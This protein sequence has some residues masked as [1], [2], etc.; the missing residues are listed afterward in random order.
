VLAYRHGIV[1]EI[2]ASEL[3]GG[4]D[5][6]KEMMRNT[7]RYASRIKSDRKLKLG[8][9][10][11][12]G[13]GE[14]ETVLLVQ[15][16]LVGEDVKTAVDLHGVSADHLDAGEVG[17]EIDGQPRLAGARG[18]HHNHHLVPPPLWRAGVWS[19]RRGGGVGGMGHLQLQPAAAAGRGSRQAAAAAAV[20][21]SQVGERYGPGRA[22][23][24]LF[25]PVCW[26]LA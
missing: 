23:P 17:R 21:A 5:Y 8:I 10:E 20:P 2:A 26:L 4:I 11:L 22:G 14:P 9:G 24:S 18:A 19:R 15:R 16:N 7:W 6:A 25:R 12:A 1:A 13:R 3:D